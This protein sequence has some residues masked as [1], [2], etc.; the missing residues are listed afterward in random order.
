[1]RLSEIQNELT[2]RDVSFEK[3][4]NRIELSILLQKDLD[5]KRNTG[6]FQISYHLY[7]Y[8]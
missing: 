7:Y 3:N 1:M 2:Q 5:V 6:C 8:C 4:Q